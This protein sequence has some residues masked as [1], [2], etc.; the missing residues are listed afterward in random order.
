LLGGSQY[1]R[2]VALPDFLRPT[3]RFTVA[4]RRILFLLGI[5]AFVAG[6]TGSQMAHTLPFA[7]LSLDMTEGAMS[8]A[9]A[10]V[11]AASLLGVGFAIAADRRG[12]RR[13]L[14]AAFT[15]LAAGSLLT[16][17]VP[18][19]AIYVISQSAVRIGVVAIA[20][21]GLVFLAE[22]LTP[23]IRGYGIGLYGLAGSLGVG[24]GLLI[25]PLAERADEAWRVLFALG[26]L[27]LL[28][29]PLLLRFLPESRAYRRGAPIAFITALRMGLNKHFWPLAGASFFVAA[30]AAPAFDFVLE[31]LISDLG[32]QAGA[33]RFLLIVTSGLGAIGLLVGGR[34]ADRLGRRPTAVAAMLIGLV[35]GLGFYL[36]D[37]GWFLAASIFL[38]TLGATM[39]TP[40]LGAMRAELFPTK[41]RATAVG[42][43]TNVAILGSIT[44]FV[45]GALLIDRIGLSATVAILGVGVIGAVLLTL[46]LPETK[47][48]DIVRTRPVRKPTPVK[49]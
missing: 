28:A 15:L 44:G 26:G 8:L 37:S 1:A 17:F 18:V 48:M 49:D 23:G 38:A 40:A 46:R 35:G 14:I 5:V 47:G 6:Y 42:W 3:D 11:R 27:G 7:R 20:G 4:D 10:G 12:R 45:V 36:L 41:V 25:L 9:F 24:S 43:V 32:W 13:P 30:F 21:V 19:A 22:E 16:A 33:A 29:L 31:R 2:R 39:L 34:A